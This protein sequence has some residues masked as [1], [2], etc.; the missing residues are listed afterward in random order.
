MDRTSGRPVGNPVLGGKMRKPLFKKLFSVA[1]ALIV[2]IPLC[3]IGKELTARDTI[4][5]T[6]AIGRCLRDEGY[7]TKEEG[8][9]F[10]LKML[11]RDGV[12]GKR[13]LRILQDEEDIRKEVDK[14]IISLGGCK[15]IAEE[16]GKPFRK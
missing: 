5:L 7:L 3:A 8:V 11:E 1:T 12:S 16:F 14:T 15:Q 6:T 4:I 13:A 2:S 10:T 9:G